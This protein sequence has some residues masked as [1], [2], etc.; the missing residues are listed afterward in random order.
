MTTATCQA[1]QALTRDPD[2]QGL[3][4]L[5]PHISWVDLGKSLNLSI[6]QFPHKWGL[7]PTFLIKPVNPKGN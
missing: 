4:R 7:F 5:Q 3:S 6:L 2:D 1:G